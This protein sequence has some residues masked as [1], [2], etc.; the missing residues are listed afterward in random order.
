MKKA[1]IS[2][3]VMAVFC[4]VIM[5]VG[6]FLGFPGDSVMGGIYWILVAIF[7]TGL[8]FLK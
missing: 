5:A 8:A 1:L 3:Y 4:A 7:L 6:S 2:V